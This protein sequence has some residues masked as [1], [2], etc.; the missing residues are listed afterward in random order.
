MPGARPRLR[1]QFGRKPGIVSDPATSFIFADRVPEGNPSDAGYVLPLLDKI[2]GAIERVQTAPRLQVH[3][4][5]GDLASM[6]RRCVRRSM[7]EGC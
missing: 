2:Q 5:A 4:V 6:M 3:S 1:A 7:R